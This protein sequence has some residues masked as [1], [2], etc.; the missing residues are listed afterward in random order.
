MTDINLKRE[1]TK[2]TGVFNIG[3]F[4]KIMHKTEQNYFGIY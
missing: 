1:N 3:V 4:I 2:A